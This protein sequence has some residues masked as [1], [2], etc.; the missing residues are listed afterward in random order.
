MAMKA[1]A[2]VLKAVWLAAVSLGATAAAAAEAPVWT[3]AP[4]VA[5]VAAAYPA[6]AKAAGAGGLVNLTCTLN[7]EGRP[8]SCLALGEKP[9]GMGFGFAAKK[10]AEKLRTDAPGMNGQEVGIPVTFDPKVLAGQAQVRAPAWAALPA[11][12]DF[13]ASFPK[14]AN[15][16][17][18]VR[19]TLVCT[20]AAGGALEGC[21][22][23]REEPAGQGYGA[24][25]LAL[26]PKI[27]VGLW[28]LDGE[29][30]VG[31]KVRVPLHYQ[32]TQ[33][34]APAN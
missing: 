7:H 15:G 22:V 26:A 11:A 21:A 13:Q 9:S 34:Q 18:D 17:N 33:A 29:P 20:V 4:S 27:R 24:G 2:A 30:V 8:R 10:L 14:S 32:L 31:A 12:Q 3:E 25:A 1:H 19:V 6:K 16:V 28:G 5:D 23:D